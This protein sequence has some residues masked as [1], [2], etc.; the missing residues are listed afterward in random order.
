MNLKEM[1]FK[2]A[3]DEDPPECV[4]SQPIDQHLPNFGDFSSVVLALTF[5]SGPPDNTEA[6]S[7]VFYFF[8]S[9]P[10]P[11][12]RPDDIL[13]FKVR[14]D[15]PFKVHILDRYLGGIASD[16]IN[17]P[18]LAHRHMWRPGMMSKEGKDFFTEAFSKPEKKVEKSGCFIATACFGSPIAKE[19]LLL[20][21]FR[22][23][24]L[25][26]TFFGRLFIGFY[27][28]VSPFFAMLISKSPILQRTI[29]TILV[30]PAIRICIA[31]SGINPTRVEDRLSFDNRSYATFPI[32]TGCMNLKNLLQVMSTF[33]GQEVFDTKRLRATTRGRRGS[34]ATSLPYHGFRRPT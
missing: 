26:R 30:G 7:Y 3:I 22:D 23:E 12:R 4:L 19:V 13:T 8:R 6:R 17:A 20:S 34:N 15:N 25:Q 29:R 27:Y 33:G 9:E 5:D 31:L 18:A 21:Q 11:N 14:F 28:S 32:K 1:G 10:D 2:K 16:A 24:V